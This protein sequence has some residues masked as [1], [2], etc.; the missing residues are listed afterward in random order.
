MKKVFAIVT[1]AI[2]L[3]PAI[4][5][6]GEPSLTPKF[7]ALRMGQ[8]SDG[9]MSRRPNP[10]VAQNC[11]GRGLACGQSYPNVRCCN[12]C[13]VPPNNSNGQCQ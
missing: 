5:Y 12:G 2:I 7:A 11:D 3:S 13:Y 10:D 4:G 9:P 8:Q 6:A 1:A